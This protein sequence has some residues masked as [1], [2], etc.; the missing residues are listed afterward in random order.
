MSDTPIG[1]EVM[2]RMTNLVKSTEQVARIKLKIEIA[3]LVVEIID[4]AKTKSE[5]ALLRRVYD[6]IEKL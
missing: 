4:T 3:R 2:A 1:D 6:R 5:I